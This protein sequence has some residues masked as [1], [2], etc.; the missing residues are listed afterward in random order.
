MFKTLNHSKLCVKYPNILD[1]IS[2][3]DK[4]LSL[5]KALD[6]SKILYWITECFGQSPL[7]YLK[8]LVLSKVFGFFQNI[9][10]FKDTSWTIQYFGQNLGYEQNL[11]YGQNISLF[12]VLNYSKARINYLNILKSHWF[13]QNIRF[14]WKYWVLFKIWNYSRIYFEQN[15][16]FWT[17]HWVSFETLG[18]DQSI[19]LSKIMCWSQSNVLSKILSMD[20]ILSIDKILSMDKISGVVKILSIDK[21]SDMDKISGMVKPL[22]YQ[23]IYTHNPIKNEKINC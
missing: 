23:Q 19:G 7:V 10:L 20:K 21:I 12:K 2:G 6:H 1:K 8:C 5:D 4:T 18:C 13:G 14:D 3:L 17:K 11:G 16:I 9:E 15:I 22:F